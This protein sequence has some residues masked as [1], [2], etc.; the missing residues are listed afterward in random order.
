MVT[1]LCSLP[2]LQLIETKLS[3]QIKWQPLGF[4]SAITSTPPRQILIQ[5]Q[6]PR[7]TCRK[8]W[9]K[10]PTA[11]M[12]SELTLSSP[13]QLLQSMTTVGEIM[14]CSNLGNLPPALYTQT[15][16]RISPW[17]ELFFL[18]SIT[19]PASQLALQWLKFYRGYFPSVWSKVFMHFIK[20]ML[21]FGV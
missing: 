1:H 21:S 2:T 12:T 19:F 14:V 5:Y 4:V 7:P 10:N 8:C 15:K 17:K 13:I 3:L 20:H 18:D 11:W 16:A 6:V 9:E